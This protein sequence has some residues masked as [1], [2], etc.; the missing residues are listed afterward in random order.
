MVEYY[1]EDYEL[2]K[3]E[4]TQ[5]KEMVRQDSLSLSLSLTHTHTHTHHSNGLS[6]TL[7]TDRHKEKLC[8]GIHPRQK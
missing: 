4:I 3:S 1:W 2:L 7:R 6:L 8:G 5:L